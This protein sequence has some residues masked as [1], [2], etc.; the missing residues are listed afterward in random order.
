MNKNKKMP[1][2]ML[3]YILAIVCFLSIYILLK[4]DIYAN[5]V[6]DENGIRW[7]YSIKNGYA[8]NVCYHSGKLGTIVS[9]PETINGYSV[10][11]IKGEKSNQNIFNS[12]ENKTVKQINIPKSVKEIG[13]CSFKNCIELENIELPNTVQKIGERAFEGCTQLTNVIINSN[14]NTISTALFNGCTNLKNINIPEGI[15]NIEKE[16]FQYCTTLQ[17][18][19]L[20]QSIQSIAD[21]A[22][23]NCYELKK[24]DLPEGLR[25]LG[26]GTFSYCKSLQEVTLPEKIERI[27]YNEFISC[28]NLNKINFNNGLLSIGNDAFNNCTSLEDVAIPD[29]V[30]TI[31]KQA[32]MNCTKAKNITLPKDIIAIEKSCFYN[33]SSLQSIILPDKIEKIEIQAFAE[34][35]SLKQINIP[36]SVKEIGE[37]AFYN[38]DKLD[39][40]QIDSDNQYYIVE[41]KILY[42]KEKS[43]LVSCINNN[44][45]EITVPDSVIRI[46]KGAFR[47][48]SYLRKLILKENLQEIESFALAECTELTDIYIEKE[49][50]MVQFND[51]WNI[52]TYAYLHDKNCIHTVKQPSNTENQII[53]IKCGENF[54]F[55]L[56]GDATNIKVRVISQGKYENSDRVSEIIESNKKG[57]YSIPNINR[58]KEILLEEKDIAAGVV[59]KYLDTEGNSV[60]EDEYIDGKIGEKY[61][62]R[63]KL[64]TGYRNIKNDDIDQDGILSD[65]LITITYVYQKNDTRNINIFENQDIS[66]YIIIIITVLVAN[67]GI[68]IIKK[69]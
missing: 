41:D 64:I 16:A 7:S 6:V 38:C 29:T 42:N 48:N 59:I 4:N 26:E 8:E 46:K 28:I 54:T 11:S 2:I 50:E 66:F 68:F 10:I 43:E 18:I 27:G 44:F 58:D 5:T 19:N 17:E 30:N 24:I 23:S 51:G 25:T 55:K 69:R 12:Y 39:K 1:I 32:F 61:S 34:C 53:Q 35:V 22:F 40:I 15:E 56:D 36:K 45:T 31:G 49:K 67:I 20:P 60:S 47:G 63:P 57:I 14:V 62:A 9:I 33:C 13:E 3:E 52:K 21:N 65:K 37:Y